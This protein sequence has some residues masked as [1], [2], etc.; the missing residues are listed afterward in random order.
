[1]SVSTQRSIDAAFSS[2][3]TYLLLS[4][5]GVGIVNSHRAIF[6]IFCA[7]ILMLVSSPGFSQ[8]HTDYSFD[9]SLTVSPSVRTS[10]A[11]HLVIDLKVPDDAPER[12]LP[13]LII[14]KISAS[15]ITCSS[16]NC[17]AYIKYD[18]HDIWRKQ[19][20][21]TSSSGAFTTS[22]V[23]RSPGLHAVEISTSDNAKW[24]IKSV[25]LKRKELPKQV[26]GI[27][28]SPF[29]ACQSPG[30]IEPGVSDVDSDLEMLSHVSQA[31][32]TY[33]STGVQQR[34]PE[35]AKKLGL[36]VYAGAWI[37]NEYT[38]DQEVRDL[39]Q[40]A[41]DGFAD[42]MV[43]GSEFLFRCLKH[44]TLPDS[45]SSDDYP[46]ACANYLIDKI[47][48]AR[49]L[50]KGR[51]P[52]STGI[53]YGEWTT[54]SWLG[55]GGKK[56]EREDLINKLLEHIDYLLVHIYPYH[57]QSCV[58]KE[59]HQCAE[60]AMEHY[61]DQLSKMAERIKDYPRVKRIV[62]GEVGWP[63]GGFTHGGAVPGLANQALHYQLLLKVI[64]DHELIGEY[65]ILK[66][67]GFLYFSAF[68]EAWKAEKEAAKG[69]GA[70]WGFSY[71]D[72]SAKHDFF[73][74]LVDPIRSDI[75][76]RETTTYDKPSCLLDSKYHLI[77]I[78]GD[79][80]YRDTN[81]FTDD[82]HGP[83]STLQTR[84]I[85]PRLSELFDSKIPLPDPFIEGTWTRLKD[86]D[87]ED[88]NTFGAGIE[89]R[90]FANVD[91]YGGDYSYLSAASER[92]WTS[93]VEYLTP[94]R[95]YVGYLWTDYIYDDPSYSWRPKQDVRYG[96]EFYQEYQQYDNRLLWGELWA[97]ASWR[98][99]NFFI[100]DYKSWTFGAVPK[101]GFKIPRDKE[102]SL[103][104]Y[105]TLPVSVTERRDFWENKIE[106]GI[107]I[108][109]MPFRWHHGTSWDMIAK[110]TKI[111]AEYLNVVRYIDDDAPSS[112]PDSDFRIGINYTLNWD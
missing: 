9:P 56:Q 89:W 100:D 72:R 76:N 11:G 84:L 101:I 16:G 90:P 79:S 20:Y 40:I 77:Q 25:T 85:F 110:K 34:I 80:S 53:L 48:E 23:V 111:Y 102:L 49:R 21:S 59:D 58:V 19:I 57:N 41:N 46:A 67:I 106:A 70:Q 45:H 112:V 37:N 105:L 71:A 43:V 63:S 27:S 62:L 24:N 99:T 78:Y 109:I 93:L 75:E 35:M 6:P 42:N 82:Y 7:I 86:I 65:P 60:D 83:V 33:S 26:R 94:L 87:W 69:T 8:P 103:M 54:P 50:T 95:F 64:E 44:K 32:R 88:R 29:R 92:L 18:Q 98:K 61:K 96:A 81:F 10:T 36:S 22:L 28:Y 52:I 91:K 4:Y 15:D 13:E 2:R 47:D 68:D 38:D 5:S 73:G 107:G 1:M 108:R 12:S 55:K 14:L 31:I 51:I 66:D 74:V 39:A 3:S 17:Y 30:G 97:D 104:P